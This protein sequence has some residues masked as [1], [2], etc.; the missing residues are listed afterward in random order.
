MYEELLVKTEELDKTDKSNPSQT[1]NKVDKVV[2]EGVLN[3]LSIVLGDIFPV[4][5]TQISARSREV[6]DFSFITFSM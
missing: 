5:L 1:F 6:K 2:E 3:M 4:F